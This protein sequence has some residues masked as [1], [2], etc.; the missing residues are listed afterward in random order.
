MRGGFRAR[1]GDRFYQEP[2][3][4]HEDARGGSTVLADCG[5]PDAAPVIEGLVVAVETST[6]WGHP[7]PSR[8]PI[9]AHPESI[10]EGSAN[11][12]AI[13]EFT[14]GGRSSTR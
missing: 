14:V 8:T 10:V 11:S 4:G 1:N 2:S 7:Q 5:M 6:S 13:L 3:A 9:R 12:A